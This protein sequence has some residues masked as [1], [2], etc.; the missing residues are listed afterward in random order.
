MSDATRGY[1]PPEAEVVV[2]G[3]EYVA[4]EERYLQIGDER[5]G[6]SKEGGLGDD[7]WIS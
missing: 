1:R 7:E 3:P 6:V 2:F 4:C 5:S